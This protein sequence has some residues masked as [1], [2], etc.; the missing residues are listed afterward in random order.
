MVAAQ[1]EKVLGVLDLV[2]QHQADV[3]NRLFSPVHIVSE[4]QIVGVPGK[5]SVL[6]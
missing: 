2:G 5:T 3:L 4:E 6:E 1:H